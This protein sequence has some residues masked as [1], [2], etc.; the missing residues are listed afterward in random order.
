MA[1]VTMIGSYS[2]LYAS[3]TPEVSKLTHFQLLKMTYRLDPICSDM[4]LIKIY[5]TTFE[6]IAIIFQ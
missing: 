4:H 6:R 1:V 3:L 2:S 5:P